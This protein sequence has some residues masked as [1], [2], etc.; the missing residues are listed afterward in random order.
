MRKTFWDFASE[1]SKKTCC[2]RNYLHSFNDTGKQT[3]LW[4]PKKM[5]PT[6][7]LAP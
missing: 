7:Q 1:L 5:E 2:Y 3:H 4:Q 6:Q